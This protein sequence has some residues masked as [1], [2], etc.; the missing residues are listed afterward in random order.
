MI[1]ERAESFW[2]QTERTILLDKLRQSKA[3][4][5]SV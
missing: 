5:L 3:G 2:R 1:T 4:S